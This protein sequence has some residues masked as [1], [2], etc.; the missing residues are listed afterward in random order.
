MYIY[1]SSKMIFL[2]NTEKLQLSRVKSFCLED[3]EPIV[4]TCALFMGAVLGW[5]QTLLCI[6]RQSLYIYKRKHICPAKKANISSKELN[7][8]YMQMSV[9]FH[10][11]IADYFG[12]FSHTQ[13]KE[14]TRLGF[15]LKWQSGQGP[16]N[17]YDTSESVLKYFKSTSSCL[18]FY[19]VVF[20]FFNP[21][22][23]LCCTLA[24]EQDFVKYQTPVLQCGYT[25]LY[26]ALNE[27][28][29][30]LCRQQL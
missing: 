19:F 27:H 2:P 6:E 28:L 25:Q 24:Y 12:F 26:I 13:K 15:L 23:C 8:E 30:S 14:R 20:F 21:D 9:P 17:S 7:S 4:L 10:R 3:V 5:F 1:C 16:E 11:H 18:P 29:L 22:H